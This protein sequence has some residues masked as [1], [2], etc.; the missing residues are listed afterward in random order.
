PSDVSSK[1]AGSAPARERP[2]YVSGKPPELAEIRLALFDVRVAAFLSFGRQ[3]VEERRV[4]RELLQSG[5]PVAVGIER[6]LETTQR[7]RA[8][9]EDFTTPLDRLCFQLRVGNHAIDEPHV[10]RS[11]RI[12]LATEE[13]DFAG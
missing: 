6:G 11:L 10:E 3:V 12:V 7:D 9:R 8:H 13:P 5:L 1:D 4:A 2:R